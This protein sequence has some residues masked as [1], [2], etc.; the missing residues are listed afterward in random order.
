MT[1]TEKTEVKVAEFRVWC[2]HCCIR[3]APNEEQTSVRGKAYHVRCASKLP[4]AT[5]KRQA[6][7]TQAR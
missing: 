2:D 3:I 7:V 6:K 4:A 5:S 1:K